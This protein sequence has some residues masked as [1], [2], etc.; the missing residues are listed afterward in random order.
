MPPCTGRQCGWAEFFQFALATCTF[1]GAA[2][3]ARTLSWNVLL[4]VAKPSLTVSVMLAVPVWPEI[5]VTV[6][7]RLPLLPP[8]TMP[9]TGASEVLSELADKV[10][11]AEAVSASEIV[12]GIGEVEVLTAMTRLVMPEIVG[13][14]FTWLTVTVNVL[15]TMLLLVPPSLTVTVTVEEPN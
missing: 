2:G 1:N 8:K 15:V 3:R 7:V 9:A 5:G 6:A 11:L 4:E 10:R 12:N 13:G 14:V